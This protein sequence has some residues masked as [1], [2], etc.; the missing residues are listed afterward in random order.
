[1]GS[2]G[3]ARE[4]GLPVYFPLGG[5]ASLQRDPTLTRIGNARLLGTRRCVAWTIRS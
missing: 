1:V 4:H 5:R 3:L 2:A